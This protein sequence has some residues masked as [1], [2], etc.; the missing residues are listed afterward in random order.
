MELTET[1]SNL[2][3]QHLLD[4]PPDTVEIGVDAA[5]Q[6]P[7]VHKEP[8]GA[9]IKPPPSRV[10]GSRADSPPRVGQHPLPSRAV[11]S[12]RKFTHKPRQSKEAT[13]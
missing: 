9:P 3:L 2:D 12:S 1:E 13:Q 10:S 4:E 6:E 5:N 8:A 11:G 7:K